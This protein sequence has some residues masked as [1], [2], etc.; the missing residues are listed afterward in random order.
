MEPDTP[1]DQAP[2]NPEQATNSE[3]VSA[4][5]DGL[6]IA[7]VRTVERLTG[8]RL[9]SQEGV[10]DALALTTGLCY[11]AAKRL[12]YPTFTYDDALSLTAEEQNAVIVAAP[13]GPPADRPAQA[14]AVLADPRVQEATQPGE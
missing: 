13:T 5:M 10:T 12:G 3:R 4:F 11:V 14:L 2:T 7:E 6:L 9:G 1:H 8:Q